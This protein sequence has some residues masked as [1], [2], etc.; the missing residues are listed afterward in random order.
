[1]VTPLWPRVGIKQIGAVQGVPWQRFDHRAGVAIIEAHIAQPTRFD[2][3]QSLGDAVQKGLAA[4][5]ANIRM[6]MR[7]GGEML[8]AAKANFEPNLGRPIGK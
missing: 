2:E 4:D 8:A 1:M 3:R 6:P 5:I 7:L